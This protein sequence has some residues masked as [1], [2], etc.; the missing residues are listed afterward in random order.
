M[1]CWLFWTNGWRKIQQ[2]AFSNVIVYLIFQDFLGNLH[3]FSSSTCR[4]MKRMLFLLDSEWLERHRKVWCGCA[5]KLFPCWRLCMAG[6]AWREGLRLSPKGHRALPFLVQRIAALNNSFL[7]N[8]TRVSCSGHVSVSCTPT[9]PPD[10]LPR[11]PG[12]GS[13]GCWP[14]LVVDGGPGA[15]CAGGCPCR[16]KPQGRYLCYLATTWVSHMRCFLSY[17]SARGLWRG[18]VLPAWADILQHQEC[19][20][21][22][23]RCWRASAPRE[24]ECNSYFFYFLLAVQS[25]RFPF[26]LSAPKRYNRRNKSCI[27]LT[28]QLEL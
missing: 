9:V 28:Q 18:W 24:T 4:L 7:R 6:F 23:R 3:F 15:C 27:I 1:I 2:M 17:L 12:Q 19:S 14:Q 22:G 25:R 13:A 11:E 26:Q 20:P 10:E 5:L 21:D 16:S 8:W